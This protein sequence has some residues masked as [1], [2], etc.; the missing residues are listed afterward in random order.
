VQ[1]VSFAKAQALADEFGIKVFETV[2]QWNRA[3]H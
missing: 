2:S 1:A 3:L